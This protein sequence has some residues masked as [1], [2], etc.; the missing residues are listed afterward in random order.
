[1]CYQYNRL[2]FD[3]QSGQTKDDKNC[4]SQLPRLAFSNKKEQC[5]AS[6]VCDRQVGKWKLHSKTEKVLSLSPG[7]DNQVKNDAATIYNSLNIG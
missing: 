7:E 3:S 5:K 6:T 4:H 1:M 2:W